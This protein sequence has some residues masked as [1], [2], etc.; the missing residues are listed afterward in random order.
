[1]NENE[2]KNGWLSILGYVALIVVLFISLHQ[3]GLCR[4]GT[5]D[6]Q[7]RGLSC[8]CTCV[9]QQREGQQVSW[10]HSTALL[11]RRGDGTHYGRR[12]GTGWHTCWTRPC[13]TP[14]HTGWCGWRRTDYLLCLP[15]QDRSLSPGSFTATEERDPD[16]MIALVLRVRTPETGETV[17]PG[18]HLFCLRTQSNQWVR[19]CA[20]GSS[21]T[22]GRAWRS[23]SPGPERTAVF[24][25]RGICGTE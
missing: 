3:G 8:P 18:S 24:H 16:G 2:K 21:W 5:G 23:A 20:C 12:S 17:E 14:G 6:P 4:T 9:P 15:D 13:R 19:V 10:S 25:G 1:M 22:D 11:H 7:D